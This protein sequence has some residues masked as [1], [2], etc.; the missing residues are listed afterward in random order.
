MALYCGVE[1]LAP[2]L[3]CHRQIVNNVVYISLD[4]GTLYALNATNGA[5]IWSV[6][7]GVGLADPTVVNNVVYVSSQNNVYALNASTGKRIWQYPVGGYPTTYNN[8]IIYV[9]SQDGGGDTILYAIN[10][11]SGKV[12][13]NYILMGDWFFNHTTAVVV[14]GVIYIGFGFLPGNGDCS[15]DDG[16]DGDVYALNATTGKLLWKTS[17]GFCD[18]SVA[19][20]N[21]MVYVGGADG[22]V[23]A[24]NA[25]TGKVVWTFNAN[26]NFGNPVVSAPTVANGVV[27]V[28]N[29]SLLAL[30][31]TNGASLWQHSFN[32]PNYVSPVVVNGV[33]YLAVEDGNIYAFHI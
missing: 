33:V 23:N 29:G 12:L 27:Y 2:I 21:N 4:S 3:E 19:V 31:A 26:G 6:F 8:G 5:P 11:V 20:A 30:N 1:R 24:L 7:L 22:S 16:G 9:S 18:A 17:A 25:T 13:W 32:S 28:S 10:A 14:N 15:G